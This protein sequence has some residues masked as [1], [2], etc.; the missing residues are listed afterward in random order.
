MSALKVLDGCFCMHR[1]TLRG[2]AF[3]AS[4]ITPHMCLRALLV[5]SIVTLRHGL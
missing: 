3:A 2:G 4:I 5:A 1:I